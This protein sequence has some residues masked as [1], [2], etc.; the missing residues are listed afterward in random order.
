MVDSCSQS[1]GFRHRVQ[2]VYEL[3]LTGTIFRAYWEI[4]RPWRE[5]RS[6]SPQHE[7]GPLG[8]AE[9]S[10]RLQFGSSAAVGGAV[11]PLVS[12]SQLSALRAEAE[13]AL[14]GRINCYSWMPADYGEK[15]SWGKNPV[16]GLSWSTRAPWPTV[17]RDSGPGDIKD[18]WEVARFPHATLCARAAAFSPELRDAFAASLLDQMRHFWTENP[19]GAGVQWASSQE[20]AFRLL[21]WVYAY[22]TMMVGTSSAQAAE[23]LIE[24]ALLE[25]AHHIESHLAYAKYAVHNNHLLSEALGLLAAGVLLPGSPHA[26]RWYKVGVRTL[27]Q[28]ASRQF[29]PDGGYIQQSHN[30]HRVALQD[31]LYSALF[32][33]GAGQA[34]PA[35]WI[36]ALDRSV[37]FL[38]TQQ[39]QA[40]GWLPNYGANDGGLPFRLSTCEYPDMRP[41]LQAASLL[42]R[43][44]RLYEPGAWDEEAA[45]WLGP[46]CLDAPLSRQTRKSKSFTATGHHVLRGRSDST[47]ATF[48]CGSLRDRFSQIDM[49]HVDIWWKGQ[50]VLVDAGTFRYNAHDVW[51]RH[52]MRT[53]AHNTVEIDGIDQ[54]H[55]FRQFKVLYWTKARLSRFEDVGEWTIAEG[56]HYG[57]RR[58]DRRCVHHRAVLHL[59]DGLWIVVDRVTGS[60][61]HHARLHWL[62][63]TDRW[64]VSESADFVQLETAAGPFFVRVF[65]GNGGAMPLDVVSGAT[66]PVRGWLSRYYA[67]K[68]AVASVVA[69]ASGPA[70]IEL[71]TVLSGDAATVEL[72]GSR[73]HIVHLGRA[74]SF[75][76]DGGGFSKVAVAA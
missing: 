46:E 65:D 10:A 35:E 32:V 22:R 39:N 72:R 38:W 31:Y 54:M 16:T 12:A 58:H 75:E 57:Y 51:H 5:R 63:G 66:D 68:D 23:M 6:H 48:R 30:Y 69:R 71:V 11:R 41:T 67:R 33:K 52:F 14:M 50:N 4:S 7:V 45:W 43:G 56:E 17:L 18:C 36:D 64:R 40:D 47:F 3:G 27:T 53:A 26:T 70:P 59:K 55:H 44:E 8:F 34:L 1:V 2:E 60:R 24:R 9:A 37:S 76:V 25:G 13:A 20:T 61:P 62:A 29:Y 74:L 28:Q 42:V 21:A 73:W 19:V 15:I 49:L